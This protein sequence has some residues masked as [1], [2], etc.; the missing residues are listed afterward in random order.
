MHSS[1]FIFRDVTNSDSSKEEIDDL[2]LSSSGKKRKSQKHVTFENVNN[3]SEG[4]SSGKRR[5][6]KPHVLIGQ[7]N[8]EPNAR[9]EEWRTVDLDSSELDLCELLASIPMDIPKKQPTEKEL[10]ITE[11]A[12]RLSGYDNM[13][14]D[15]KFQFVSSRREK[16]DADSTTSTNGDNSSFNGVGSVGKDT[17]DEVCVD[18]SEDAHITCQLCGLF[19]KGR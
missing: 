3:E 5:R 6:E 8:E 10:E 19:K 18:Y 11:I 1:F 9:K 14:F 15:E 7:D 12:N 16:S 13:S 17:V 2:K 4:N